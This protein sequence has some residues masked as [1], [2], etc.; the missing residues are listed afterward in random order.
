MSSPLVGAPSLSCK[1]AGFYHTI[2]RR[3]YDRSSVSNQA[4]VGQIAQKMAGRESPRRALVGVAHPVGQA[5]EPVGGDGDE[6]AFLMSEA[7]ARRIAIGDGCEHRA[8]KQRS[9]I[10]ILVA[11]ADHLRD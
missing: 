10:G 3:R 6:I 4:A 5:A 8:Q 2:S 1:P 11:G 7:L 9:A